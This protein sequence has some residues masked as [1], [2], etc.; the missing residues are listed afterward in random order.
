MKRQMT[1]VEEANVNQNREENAASESIHQGV[2][3]SSINFVGDYDIKQT[4]GPL[5][6]AKKSDSFITSHAQVPQGGTLGGRQ[7]KNI[8]EP[9]IVSRILPNSDTCNESSNETRPKTDNNASVPTSSGTKEMPIFPIVSSKDNEQN[10]QSVFR[11]SAMKT[12]I[13]LNSN[14]ESF[15]TEV[16]RRYCVAAF[17]CTLTWLLMTVV[18]FAI[19]SHTENLVK[20]EGLEQ[21]APLVAAGLLGMS[22]FCSAVP[23]FVK[24][25][26]QRKLGEVSGIIVCSIVV[27]LVAF[28]TDLLLA[29]F[30]TPVY[31][32]PVFGSNV[33]LLRWCEWTPLAFLMTFLTEACRTEDETEGSMDKQTLLGSV[34]SLFKSK[35]SGPYK[36]RKVVFVSNS[37]DAPERNCKNGLRAEVGKKL[38]AAYS[39]AWCQGISTLCG[40]IFPFCPDMISWGI[41]MT[42]SC[43]LY[44]VIFVRVHHRTIEFKMQKAGTSIA[45]QEL[46]H[47]AKLSLRLLKTCRNMWTVLV[48]AYCIY[49][50]GPLIFPHSKILN[51]KGLGM[52][53]ESIIDVL[54]KSIYMLVIVEVHDTIFDRGARTER[55]LEELRKMMGVVWDNSSDVICISVRGANGNVTTMLSP[56][57]LKIY[58]P[59][60][61]GRNELDAKAIAFELESGVFGKGNIPENL[62]V[63]PRAM[64]NVQFSD[65]MSGPNVDSVRV[66]RPKQTT[67]EIV[68]MVQLVV[69]AWNAEKDVNILMHELLRNGPN[70]FR[71]RCEANITRMEENAMLIVVRDISERV[72]RFEAEKKVI[73]ETTARLKD[74]AA[75]RF[76]RHEVKNGLLAAIELCDSICES[77]DKDKIGTA[78]RFGNGINELQRQEL[79]EYNSDASN[80]KRAL[81]ELDRTLHEILD[82]ILAEAMARDVVHEVYEPKLERVDVRKVLYSTMNVS[83]SNKCNAKRFPINTVPSFLPEYALDPQ[84]LKYI[85]RNA[86]SNACKYG[87]RGGVVSTELHWDHKSGML[88]MD[89]INLPGPHHEEILKLGPLAS[90]LVFSPRKRLM[91]HSTTA[92]NNHVTASHS[93]GDGAWIMSRCAKT[94]GGECDINF[95]RSRTVLTFKCPVTPY[96]E[97]LAR[98]HISHEDF[99]MP[100][101]V[102]GIGIDDSKIQ[103]KLLVRFFMY[104]GI[105]E[106]R[107]HIFGA[108]V[109]EIKGFDDWAVNFIDRHPDDYF[110]MIIDE[111]LDVQDEDA[112]S[113]VTISG[114]LSVSDMRSRLIPDQERR[115]LAL[116]RSA[117]DSASDVA[118]YQARAHGFLP[119][120][121][122]KKD[123]VREVLVPMWLKRFPKFE[124]STL[125]NTIQG[126]TVEDYDNDV[127]MEELKPCIN[128]INRFATWDEEELFEK[129]NTI[130]EKLHNLKGDLLTMHDDTILFEVIRMISSL[131]GATPPDNF[132]EKWQEIQSSLMTYSFERDNMNH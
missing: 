35:K 39:L 74:A 15:I 108:N 110:L 81:F 125:R 82:T 7:L 43:A 89:V 16:D 64:H 17:Y 42:F 48:V 21:K 40:W 23:F 120:A 66:D 1:A 33:Y 130:W 114:S 5:L 103:R 107:I 65:L 85:H 56:T 49:N 44:A 53:C 119:K 95:M 86:I 37:E 63:H 11:S 96:N 34:L 9:L 102:Y 90:E 20:L 93:S 26:S 36:V 79:Y 94:L 62:D 52:L 60:S 41:T 115:V 129:W 84:L 123:S 92:S 126:V 22:L 109:E 121:P 18:S 75:N 116:I 30:Q 59:E 118:I 28:I 32:D 51:T 111:N 76:T 106:D 45:E 72:R 124:I 10:P 4:S 50:I 88:E 128:E 47:W 38:K 71:I 105:P 117:N 14:M 12:R 122:I 31:K 61:H 69:K 24:T 58:S 99:K 54:F 80:R 91:V 131:I 57:Y 112:R 104:V 98:S 29:N 70:P 67:D 13:K 78:I 97:M 3:K 77:E 6:H 25:M 2:V 73:S 113:Q 127:S 101:N 19:A 83:S 55:R 68:S 100:K 27:H 46:Y 8:T 87:K 132:S